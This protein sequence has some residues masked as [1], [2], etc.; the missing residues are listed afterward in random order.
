MVFKYTDNS[1]TSTVS[2]QFSPN[3][4]WL[5][6]DY[7]VALNQK[8]L[9]ES[10]KKL[11][12]LIAPYKILN[13]FEKGEAIVLS[14]AFYN[15]YYADKKKRTIIF[16]IN[17]GRHGAGLTGIPFTDSKKL[18]NILQIDPRGIRCHEPSA[19]FIYDVILAFGGPIKFFKNFF[20]QSPFPLC[21]VQKNN[22]GNW[23]NANYYDNQKL[24]KNLLP[25]IDFTMNYYSRMPIRRNLAYCLGQGKN[26]Q[27]LKKWNEKKNLF[28]NIIPLPHPRYIV[29]YQ[30]KLKD[31]FIDLYLKNFGHVR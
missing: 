9:T 25:M 1:N 7:A 27:F 31:Q 30:S 11:I 4:Q 20:F 28:K 22:K 18:E 21:L 19:T 2:D 13:P 15:K 14:E 10:V 24:L 6:A 23:C 12:T 16:G 3:R 8:I 5:F 26:F 29:Q 17:P